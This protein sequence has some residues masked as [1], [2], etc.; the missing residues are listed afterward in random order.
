MRARKPTSATPSSATTIQAA[1]TPVFAPPLAFQR[2]SHGTSTPAMA[3][4]M[5]SDSTVRRKNSR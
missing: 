5:A 1:R 3:V 2:S 4:A